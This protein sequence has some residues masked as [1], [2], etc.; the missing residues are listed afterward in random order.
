MELEALLVQSLQLLGLGM[1]AVFTILVMLIFLI[2]IISKL[3]PEE[4]V[5][6]PVPAPPPAPT[7]IDPA[8]VAAISAAVQQ[9]RKNR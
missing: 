6:V 3:L 5:T 8:H 9:H 4:T 2:S 1:G 7:G